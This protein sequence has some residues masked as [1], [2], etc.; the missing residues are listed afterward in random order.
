MTRTEVCSTHG[1]KEPVGHVFND[2]PEDRG[3]LRDRIN[4]ASLRF[5]HRDDT[6]A[7]GY[8][9]IRIKWRT[10]DERRTRFACRWLVFGV[11]PSY[12]VDTWVFLTLAS[13]TQ[14]QHPN[15]AHPQSR[16]PCRS[17]CDYFYLL[18]ISY[19]QI[20][21]YFFQIHDP[22]TLDRLPSISV[23][24]I[25]AIFYTN[26][27]QRRIAETHHLGCALTFWAV[28][29]Q[30]LVTEVVRPAPSGKPSQSI[31]TTSAGTGR[32][33]LPFHS[34]Q[35]EAAVF[36]RAHPPAQPESTGCI[37][38][39]NPSYR[40][41]RVPKRRKALNAT[42]PRVRTSSIENQYVAERPS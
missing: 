42:Q 18:K 39:I 12:F 7:E 10:V 27:E 16:E 38:A 17:K 32:T 1:D 24:A 37:V 36:A 31:R 33:L 13:D 28:A 15:A 14:A 11:S 19:R 9:I 5:I 2:G 25:V 35:L 8:W 26:D 41:A 3:G 34:G 22:T 4:S 21:E 6:A 40:T 30:S 20:L 23:Q 29:G